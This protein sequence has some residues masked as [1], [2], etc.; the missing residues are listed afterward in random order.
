MWE[1][2]TTMR[3]FFAALDKKA[4]HGPVQRRLNLDGSLE[5]ACSS[6]LTCGH[7]YASYPE[8]D[9]GRIDF[10][11]HFRVHR[12]E[13]SGYVMCEECRMGFATDEAHREHRME[14]HDEEM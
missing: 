2:G 11:R 12:E 6:K 3:P 9:R 7:C 4:F 13:G 1:I 8:K 14:S 10:S 5:K